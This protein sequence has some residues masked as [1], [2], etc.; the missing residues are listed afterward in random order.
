MVTADV[1]FVH[2][3]FLVSSMA[4]IEYHLDFK[5]PYFRF[6]LGSAGLHSDPQLTFQLVK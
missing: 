6:M 2:F 3:D 4:H 5:Y 1:F